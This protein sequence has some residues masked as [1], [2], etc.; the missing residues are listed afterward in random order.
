MIGVQEFR[1]P[2]HWDTRTEVKLR[3]KILDWMRDRQKSF[4]RFTIP[5]M[6]YTNG[7]VGMYNYSGLLTW[8]WVLDKHDYMLHYPLNFIRISAATMGIVTD[9]WAL[10]YDKSVVPVSLSNFSFDIDDDHY[11]YKAGVGHCEFECIKK[12]SSCGIGRHDLARFLTNLTEFDCEDCPYEWS[13]LCLQLPYKDIT[14]VMNSHPNFIGPDIFYYMLFLKKLFAEGV[15][16]RG[17]DL[18]HYHCY[19]RADLSESK[20]KELMESYFV[21]LLIAFGLWLYLPLLIHYFPSSSATHSAVKVPTGMFPSHKSPNYFGRYVKGVFC[22]YTPENS[23]ASLVRARRLLFLAV[24]LFSPISLFLHSYLSLAV[25]VILLIVSLVPPYFSKHVTPE[26]E[27]TLLGWKIPQPLIR[28]D[29]NLKEYQLLAA[30]MQER[31][32][33]VFSKKFWIALINDFCY[34]HVQNYFSGAPKILQILWG[35]LVFSFAVVV[36]VACYLTPLVYFL[37]QMAVTVYSMTYGGNQPNSWISKALSVI[38]GVLIYITVLC[39]L[40]VAFF[41]CYA[42]TEVSI[43]TLIGGAILPS[44]AFPYFILIG[45]TV[46]AV[47]ALFHSL[48]EDY[49]KLIEEIISI[50]DSESKIPMTKVFDPWNPVPRELVRTEVAELPSSYTISVVIATGQRIE[51]MKHCYVA[52]FLH[53]KLFDHVAGVCLPMSRQVL[54]IVLQVVAILF[55]GFIVI[56]VKN[57]YHLEAEVD[58]IFSLVSIVAIAFVPGVL[59]VF[60]YKSYFGG[61]P[62]QAL[63][64]KVYLALIEYFASLD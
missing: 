61:K 48:H 17:N 47:Y 3:D 62:E 12:N 11:E 35:I 29:Q 63:K 1:C 31:L 16:L 50:L 28:I 56:W 54:F 55:Y 8:A 32:Y 21:I 46:G 36:I 52:T 43:F 40:L 2:F 51:I 57:V 9:D 37:T 27:V 5:V 45:S 14:T 15:L 41:W 44:M 33:L 20:R 22:Y 6:G 60:A 25:V 24:I 53:R 4:N 26:R 7:D 23:T 49:D 10:D 58:T 64:Q 34:K 18:N 19:Q 42:F 59:R 30:V 39:V 13:L 38:H